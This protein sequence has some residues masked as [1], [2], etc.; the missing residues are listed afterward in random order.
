MKILFATLLL[1]FSMGAIAHDNV[2][3]TEVLEP[4]VHEAVA[5]LAL[6]IA[7]FPYVVPAAKFMDDSLMMRDD[8]PM[9]MIAPIK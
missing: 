6:G 7:V 3:P 1:S 5:G 2:M 4:G 8:S 9:L